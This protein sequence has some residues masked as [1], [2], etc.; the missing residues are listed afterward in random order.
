MPVFPFCSYLQFCWEWTPFSSSDLWLPFFVF[1]HCFVSKCLLP[2]TCGLT[3]F[4]KPLDSW[5]SWTLNTWTY[6]RT[7]GPVLVW[8]GIRAQ[9]VLSWEGRT[10][11]RSGSFVGLEGELTP[12]CLATGCAEGV[13]A[14]RGV[15][16]NDVSGKEAVGTGGLG[17][18]FYGI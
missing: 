7:V 10:A 11:E 12:K 1:F 16:R 6:V 14:L 8:K 5:G 13:T 18:C 2:S 4:C 15:L 17:W 9:W 3:L